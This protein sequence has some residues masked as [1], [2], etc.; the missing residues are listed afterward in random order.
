MPYIDDK[1]ARH[2]LERRARGRGGHVRE[3]LR[4]LCGSL[5]LAGQAQVEGAQGAQ[6]Q[7]AF[8]GA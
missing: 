2:T 3:P 8:E 4:E 7:P 6:E 5:G 1:A